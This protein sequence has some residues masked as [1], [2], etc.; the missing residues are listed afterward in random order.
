MKSFNQSLSKPTS[1]WLFFLFIGWFL[2]VIGLFI[3]ISIAKFLIHIEASYWLWQFAQGIIFTCA[4][5]LTMIY[6]QGKMNINIW[7]FI[8]LSP[9]KNASFY[10]LLGLMIPVSLVTVG[11]IIAHYLGII[12]VRGFN[13]SWE[14]LLMVLLNT[15]IAFLYEAFPEEVSLRGYLYSVLR[16]RLGQLLSILFQTI[17][18][19]LFPIGVTFLQWVFRLGP[20]EI[21]PDYVLLIFTFGLS[22]QIIRLLTNN[23]WASIGFHLAYLEIDRFVVPQG[24]HVFFDGIQSLLVYDEIEPGIGTVFLLMFM[25]ILMSMIIGGILLYIKQKRVA[26]K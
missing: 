22:L 10:L 3:A 26:K 20:M 18:F 25:V 19:V 8:R 12:T 13:L 6:L 21:T 16:I 23:L 24:E 11:A 7:S 1:R 4:V 15:V 14:L 5:F 9:F 17:L 2:P